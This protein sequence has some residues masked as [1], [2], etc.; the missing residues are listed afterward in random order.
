M[1]MV[2]RNLGGQL[3]VQAKGWLSRSDLTK[4]INYGWLQRKDG[5]SRDISLLCS[6]IVAY[7]AL[8]PKIS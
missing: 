3:I 6:F 8:R 5:T 7:N 2:K 4:F 1:D